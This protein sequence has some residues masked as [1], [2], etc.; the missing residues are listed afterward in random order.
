MEMLRKLTLAALAML[1]GVASNLVPMSA[2]SQDLPPARVV[3][4]GSCYDNNS[5]PNLA[6]ARNKLEQSLPTTIP[7]STKSDLSSQRA[8]LTASFADLMGQLSAEYTDCLALYNRDVS[9]QSHCPNNTSSYDAQ[10]IN[11]CNNEAALLDQQYGAL[12]GRLQAT[13]TALLETWIPAFGKYVNGLRAA[14]VPANNATLNASG[15]REV[16]NDAA[17]GVACMPTNMSCS[18]F[19][20]DIGSELAKRGLPA[21]GTIWTNRQL[22]A[23]AIANALAVANQSQWRRV[24]ASQVQGLADR[25]ILVVAVQKHAGHGHVAVAAP[26]SDGVPD[27]GSGPYLRDGDS[28]HDPTCNCTW[29]TRTEAHHQSKAFSTSPMWYE[30]VPSAGATQ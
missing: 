14:A 3:A 26:T 8:Q 27:Q 20:H 19:F 15:L 9:H 28:H 21:D 24:P 18:T 11:S 16:M 7:A 12:Q 22:D 13:K 25:G 23:N 17:G 2:S 1:L 29:N 4:P 30:W 5:D 10:Y 6:A